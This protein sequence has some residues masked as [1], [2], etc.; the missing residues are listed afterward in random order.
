MDQDNQN[1]QTPPVIPE[2]EPKS[3]T[4]TP[5]VPVSEPQQSQAPLP[6]IDPAKLESTI[7]EKVSKGV[8]DKIA[9]ALGLTKEEKKSL[10][11]DPDELA[12]FIQD[13]AKKGTEAVLTEREQAE[14]DAE[15]ERQT[16]LNEGAQRFQN[17]WRTQY[18]ELA[19]SGRVP[20]VVNPQDP[21]DPGN[22][23]RVKI[24]TKLKQIID[25][26]AERGVDYVPTLKEVFYENPDV[27]KIETTTGATVPVSGGGRT[28]TNAS[29]ALPYDS[30]HKMD[31]DDLIKRKY[32]N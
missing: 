18:N 3:E 14:Q 25:N 10:P 1:P 12:K 13:N 20:K 8:L 22:V 11:T 17:L 28:I 32:Q 31:V 16:Q 6:S 2:T 23:A 30:L 27:L 19:E 24:L 26:N 9:G 15:Q 7:T 29:S 5:Q 21:Q 4:Q